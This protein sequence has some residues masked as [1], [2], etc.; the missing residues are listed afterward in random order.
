MVSWMDKKGEKTEL[1]YSVPNKNQCK[2]C[3]ENAGKM[4]LIGPKA[5]YLNGVFEYASGK[6]NQ[7]SHWAA[8]G[9]LDG[10]DPSIKR[11]PSPIWNDS[12]SADLET[13]ARA[14]LD[15]NCSHCHNPKGQGGSSGLNLTFAE[16]NMN[17][18]GVCKMPVAA[19]QGS[20]QLKYGILPGV[21][22]SSIILYRMNSIKLNEMMPELGRQM[23][24]GEGVELIREWIA[25]LKGKCD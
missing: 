10:F 18:L 22:D 24:H 16:K 8:L 7:L 21:P 4:N 12:T 14:Y 19:G 9:I 15:I 11:M 1:E 3:H 25:T 6:Q 5:L 2:A 23:I 20:G 13:R 17:H